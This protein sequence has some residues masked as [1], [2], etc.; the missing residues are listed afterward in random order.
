MSKIEEKLILEQLK[1]VRNKKISFWGA[2]CFLFEFI[3]KNNL[4][5]YNIIGIID[6][7]PQFNNA[8][9]LSFKIYQPQC[10]PEQPDVIICTIKNNSFRAYEQ[11]KKDSAFL[12]PKTELLPNV[13]KK[14]NIE[15]IISNKIFIIDEYGNKMQASYIPGLTV[16]WQGI[17]ASIEIMANPMPRFK[18]CTFN[19]GNNTKITIGSTQYEL[20]NLEVDVQKDFSRLIIGNQFSVNGCKI[21]LTGEKNQTITIG[22]DCMFSHGITIRSSDYH[23]IYDTTSKKV[24]NFSKDII[25]KNHVWICQ[26]ATLLK[27]SIIPSNC[28]IGANSLVNKS[29][30]KENVIISGHPAKITKTNVNWDRAIPTDFNP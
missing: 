30:D 17:N 23:S 21:W 15:K 12:F 29:F 20:S 18:N 16:I 26:N 22:D 5:N 7:N 6:N 25:I 4:E 11:I 24:I 2:S 13:F 14:Q 8:N 9:L 27:G 19:C 3:S 1:T 10:L 28:I